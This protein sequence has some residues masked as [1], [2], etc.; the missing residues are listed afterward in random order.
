M[1][2]HG[3]ISFRAL[4]LSDLPLIHRW[5]NQPH[6]LQWYGQRP[7]TL[8]EVLNKHTPRIKGQ[9]PTRC[10][11]ILYGTRP[12]GYIQTYAIR[13][14]PDY[15]KYVDVQENAAGVDLYIGDAGYIHLGLGPRII[16]RFMKA[17]V[18]ADSAITSVIIGPEPKNHAAIR[19]YEKA[20]FRYLKTIQVPG[21][22]EPEYL[23]RIT[24]AELG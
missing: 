13:D 14:Y 7:L 18:F 4:A 2:Q 6:V 1:I 24:P 10:F 11:L 19:A 20:G 16:R 15:A 5:R 23:M 17:I 8:E 21:E 9:E 22:P 12:I 3:E